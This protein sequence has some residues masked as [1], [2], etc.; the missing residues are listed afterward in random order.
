MPLRLPSLHALLAR[1]VSTIVYYTEDVI[2]DTEI[3]PPVFFLVHVN[4]QDLSRLLGRRNDT[5]RAIR[6]ILY[7]AGAQIGVP[8]TLRIVAKDT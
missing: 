2:I 7:G 3:G 4:P 8:L 6:T 1:I 5:I